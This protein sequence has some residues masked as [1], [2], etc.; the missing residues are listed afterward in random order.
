VP[1]RDAL[2]ART[3]AEAALFVARALSREL[4][5]GHDHPAWRDA[6]DSNV[7]VCLREQR[8]DG[9]LARAFD[10]RTGAPLSWDGT[11]GLAWIPALVEASSLADGEAALAAARRAGEAFAPDVEAGRLFGSPEDTDRAPTSEDG[12]VAVM[13]YV[14]LADVSESDRERGRW[15][16]LAVRAADWTLTFRYVYDVALPAGSALAERGFRSDGLDQASPANQHLHAYGLICLPEMA[17]LAALT[18]DRFYLD[19]TRDNLAGARQMICRFDGDLGGRRG[20]MAERFYQSDYGGA[21]GAVD[22]LSHAWCLGLLLFACEAARDIPGL[23][24]P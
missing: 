16:A 3:N 5:A 12:Y 10:G 2:S 9:R 23:S 18:G 17:R 20:M 7:A 14:A 8:A 19:Q 4:V 13:A 21:K 6:L 15:L 22:G 24:D 11:S 1:G